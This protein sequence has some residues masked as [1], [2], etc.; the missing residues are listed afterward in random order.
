[1]RQPEKPT[2]L[3]TVFMEHSCPF[4]YVDD[5]RLKR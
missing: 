4:C 1:M 5:V 2:L 3:A